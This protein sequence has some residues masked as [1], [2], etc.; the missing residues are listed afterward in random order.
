MIYRKKLFLDQTSIN[1]SVRICE[2]FFLSLCVWQK[3]IEKKIKI[4]GKCAFF[5]FS[6]VHISFRNSRKKEWSLIIFHLEFF[7]KGKCKKKKIFFMLFQWI[8]KNF[9]NLIWRHLVRLGFIWYLNRFCELL[10]WIG[11]WILIFQMLC[12]WN[13][14]LGINLI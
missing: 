12:K 7:N 11:N 14:L 1:N 8:W 6:L 9:V 13:H 3:K 4:W 2:L 5:I 10:I